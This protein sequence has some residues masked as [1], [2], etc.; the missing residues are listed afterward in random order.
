LTLAN[1]TEFWIFAVI[2]AMAVGI[3]KAG[4]GVGVGM[5]ATPLLALT[6]TVPEA[7][8]IMLPLLILCDALSVYYYRRSFDRSSIKILIP[9]ACIGILCGTFF[10]GYFIDNERILKIVIGSF[11]LLFVFVQLTGPHIFQFVK[12]RE[13]H[14]LEGFLL[15]TT[16]GF[17]STLLHAGGPPII[18][19][20]VSKK[21]N[22]TL[23][24][25]T[26]AVFFAITNLVKLLPYYYLG[27]LKMGQF[28]TF[29]VLAPISYLGI[30]VG[31]AL[32]RR[33]SEIWFSRA[34]HLILFFTGL[35]LITGKGLISLFFDY[36]QR[37]FALL[38]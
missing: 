10:F 2:A 17:T 1:P 31:L 13:L 21:F 36:Y 14:P 25:G 5:I 9:G 30:K 37:C 3:S 12:N 34:I 32:N 18:I 20:L 29:L 35:Q 23:F 19:Y 11:T 7:A 15:G 27:L 26:A 8:A 16:S 38:Y 6:V 22:R 33:F 4:F 24:V 28:R